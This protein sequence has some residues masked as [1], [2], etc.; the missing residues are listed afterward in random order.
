MASRVE[1]LLYWRSFDELCFQ[2]DVYVG[3]AVNVTWKLF[4][5][6]QF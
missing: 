2:S 4:L 1:F 3:S 6:S 5:W